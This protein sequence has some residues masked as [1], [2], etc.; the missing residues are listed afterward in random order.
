MNNLTKSLLTAIFICFCSMQ[1]FS[2]GVIVG[3]NRNDNDD[4]TSSINQEYKIAFG[5]PSQPGKVKIYALNNVEIQSHSGKDVV[6]TATGM[7]P[8]PKRAEGLRP[9]YNTMV[10]NTNMGLSVKEV[11]NTVEI[12]GLTRR[13]SITYKVLVPVNA[14]LQVYSSDHEGPKINI[15]NFSNEIEIDSRFGNIELEDI[16]GPALIHNVHGRINVKFAKVNPKNPISITSVHGD[17]DV[18]LP[19]KTPANLE[20]KSSHGEIYTDMD[21]AFNNS[22]ENMRQISGNRIEGKL[23][24]GGV[25]IYLESTHSNIYL[26]KG[27]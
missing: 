4:Q 11:D 6:I 9:V 17:V 12:N 1:S 18:T 8:V 27:N 25:E 22:K 5:K 2:Q 15:S 26:R 13:G 21:I 20:L 14:T 16:T 19:A 23:N 3:G 24:G 7:R 10:D